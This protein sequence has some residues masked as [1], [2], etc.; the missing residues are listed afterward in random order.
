M[1]GSYSLGVDHD[2]P[3]DEGFTPQPR[4]FERGT[5][6][7]R[8]GALH[9]DLSTLQSPL[10]TG[11]L[12]RSALVIGAAGATGVGCCYLASKLTLVRAGELALVRSVS[13][14]CR[15]LGPGWHLI[16]T[17]TC[18]VVKASMT[19]PVVQL[20]NLTIL[21]I[22]PGELGKGQ[23][24]GQPLLL[25]PG[26]HLLNDPLFNFLGTVPATAPHIAVANTLH[27]I[28]VGRE[29]LGLCLANA[30][31]HF[32]GPGRHAICHARFEFRGLSSAKSEYLTVGSKHRVFL[33]EGRLGL[34]WDGGRPIVLEPSPERA[35]QCFDSPTFAFERSV[36]ATQQVIV[37]GSV[38]VITVRQGFVGVSFKD[39][40][41][42]V[43]PPGRH[44]ISSVTHAFSGFLPTGQQTMQ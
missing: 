41:L 39:G 15:A 35:P 13:G 8:P 40:S 17:V 10:S 19:Q 34:A 21:R 9:M 36:P 25:G 29:E 43:L 2:A 12:L 26:V 6:E 1:H 4:P 22:L 16:D 20:G 3:C 14:E 5:V 31:G 32:L 38:K 27:V 18:D 44:V 24:N 37:H 7:V 11:G 42:E 33:A 28:T 23:M 30:Q